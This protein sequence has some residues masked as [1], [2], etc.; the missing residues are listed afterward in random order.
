MIRWEGDSFRIEGTLFKVLPDGGLGQEVEMGDA[1]FFVFKDRELIDLLEET[2]ER[3]GPR[4]IVELGIF[5]GGSTALLL[6]LAKP[7]RLLAVDRVSVEEEHPVATY[8]AERGLGDVVSL[9][10]EVDQADRARLAELIETE[11][12]SQ[13]LDLVVDDCSHLY[14][15]TRASLNELL[16]RL[17][18]G[19]LYV[20]EDWYWAHTP[21][22][23]EPLEG[24]WSDQVPLTRLLF[25]LVIA[26]PSVP[27]LITEI[28][29]AHKA[30]VLER[31]PAEIDPGE[32][33]I[34][35]C[36]NPRGRRLIDPE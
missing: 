31:G 26:M 15:P 9:Y 2:I 17:R 10:G 29:V 32:F 25:E 35:A 8:A 13:P 28:S 7:E 22:G 21:L 36:S 12:G 1:R 14:E 4:R 3:L 33:D 34:S 24:M 5:Q 6:E 18:P 16:P 23:V 11:F 27:G 20:I 19:G 30:V